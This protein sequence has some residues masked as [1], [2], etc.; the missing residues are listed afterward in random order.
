[1]DRNYGGDHPEQKPPGQHPDSKQDLWSRPSL[2]IA[3][4]AP[5]CGVSASTIR[6]HLAAG[7]FLTAHQQ[8]SPISGQRGLWRIPTRDLLAAGLR[9]RH[10][11]SLGQQQKNE[12]SSQR[13]E[14]ATG[15]PA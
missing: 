6:R 11:R 2:T 8:P 1:V 5:L 14:S 15:R 13:L 10:A 7:H 12:P 3:E 4:A 9:P